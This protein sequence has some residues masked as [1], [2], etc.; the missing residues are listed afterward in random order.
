MSTGTEGRLLSIVDVYGHRGKRGGVLETVHLGATDLPSGDWKIGG[1]CQL[2]GYQC[3]G[4]YYFPMG[5]RQ[6]LFV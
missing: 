5:I 3:P 1:N 4:I 2:V 6:F